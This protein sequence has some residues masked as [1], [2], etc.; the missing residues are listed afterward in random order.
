MDVHCCRKLK[1]TPWCWPPEDGFPPPSGFL[2]SL[3]RG[4]ALVAP[5]APAQVTQGAAWP[6]SFR[7][8]PERTKGKNHLPRARLGACTSCVTDRTVGVSLNLE[9]VIRRNRS[10]RQRRPKLER[11]GEPT[12]KNRYQYKSPE[13]LLV[14]SGE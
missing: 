5:G 6:R 7:A 1:W 12:P 9:E 3:G 10:L 14:L 4:F 11:D 2:R 13:G 8:G